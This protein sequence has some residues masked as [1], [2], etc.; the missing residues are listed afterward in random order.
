RRGDVQVRGPVGGA[1]EES[2]GEADR[3]GDGNVRVPGGR[4]EVLRYVRAVWCGARQADG[5]RDPS[6]HGP[7]VHR[8]G[9][10]RGRGACDAADQRPGQGH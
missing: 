8:G 6:V 3:A 1:D 10:G 7:I 2:N 4:G 5:L 9:L